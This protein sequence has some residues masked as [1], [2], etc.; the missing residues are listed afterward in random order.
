MSSVHET[1]GPVPRNRAI[2]LMRS[3]AVFGVIV[4]HCAPRTPGADHVADFFLNVSVPFFLL[5]ALFFFWRE[6]DGAGAGGATP[7]LCRR[8]PR[9]L[10][11]YAAWTIIYL[12]AKG[13]KLALQG[14]PLATEFGG[15]SL[16]RILLTGG[17][18][19]QL[20]FVP[21]LLCGFAL[22]WL[23]SPWVRRMPG[24]LLAT[25][26]L[27]AGLV[28][29]RA[30]SLIP[31]MPA[32]PIGRLMALYADWILWMLAVTLW[33]A[34]VSRWTSA[35]RPRAGLGVGLLVAAVVLDL[36]IV[37]RLVPYAW[38]LHSLILATL[39]LGACIAG[40]D[41]PPAFPR[42]IEPF[43]RVSF[44]IYLSHHLFLEAIELADV[45]LGGRFS[46]PY[47]G[48]TILLVG[49]VVFVVSAVFTRQVL[50]WPR[51]A[52]LLVGR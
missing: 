37:A 25:A 46:Q 11:P 27:P 35:W 9:L 48:G 42:W 15:E 34:A 23:L 3:V 49:A 40:V 41:L 30:E 33:A 19:V 6:L 38:R 10:L 14:R 50:R 1:A 5:T 51:L 36:L 43:L 22:A 21:L 26:L 45:R 20:Y 32:N 16:L 13:V 31:A 24:W 7:A 8:L 44:G 29:V 39:F 17:A 52:T 28:L 12:G 2:E 18:A 4:I 47:S